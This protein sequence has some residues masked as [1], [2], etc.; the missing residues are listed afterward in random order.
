MTE[1]TSEAVAPDAEPVS[2]EA[3]APAAVDPG[4]RYVEDPD[5]V[6]NPLYMTAH[7]DTSGTA[8]AAAARIEQISPVFAQARLDA[9]SHAVDVVDNVASPGETVSSSVVLPGAER[10][11][12]E[13]IDSLHTAAEDAAN[14]PQ[15]TEGL[16]PGQQ[17]AAQEGEPVN[18]N[19]PEA[20]DPNTQPVTDEAVTADEQAPA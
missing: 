15:L 13:A 17:E 7:V 19:S 6:P 18:P 12:D 16:T 20:Q 1:T 9:L 11:Y 5:W 10:S 2:A 3:T 14:H 4:T 8:G